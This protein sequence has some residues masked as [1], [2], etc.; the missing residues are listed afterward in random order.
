MYLSHFSLTNFRNFARLD[1]DVPRGPVIVYGDNAQGKTSLL[2]AI[3]YLATFMSFHATNDQQLIHLWAEKEPVV[4]SR[5]AT[6]FYRSADQA[7]NAPH[8]ANR[9]E[10]RL[11]VDENG[12]NGARRLRKE[13]LL[14]G[15][16]KKV[17]EVIGS[18]TA[19]LFLPQ[20]LQIIEGSPDDRR[21]Y[22]N[23]AMAQVLPHFAA[24][25][26]DYNQ[27]V[28]QRNALLKQ[29]AEKGIDSRNAAGQLAYWDEQLARK[30]S[31]IISHRIRA[32]KDLDRIA[33]RVHRDLTQGQEALRLSYIP[34]FELLQAPVGQFAL[35]INTVID[36]S[37]LSQEKI[38]ER[39][40]DLIQ[41]SRPEELARGITKYGPHRDEL[42]FLSNQLDLGIY[43]SRGQ[44]RSA[45]MSM[46]L[47]EVAWMKER[48]GEWPV[49][50]LDEVLAELDP[51]RRV[52]LLH[53]LLESE[54]AVMTTTDLDMFDEKFVRTAQV[55]HVTAGQISREV[56]QQ[57]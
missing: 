25:L 40:I 16:K 24:T 22:L 10:V 51:I 21:R 7:S 26:T 2:E 45:V 53:Y 27:V 49:L 18:F 52:D 6:T 36:R 38:Y 28:S 41:Q 31:E 17:S 12:G 13:I 39:F 56:R 14:D 1:I 32:I 35:P 57:D 46:K 34:S 42:R 50:L 44:V 8:K 4:V 3:Y 20:M 11:I 23:L 9:I 5:I 54:Q 33:A 29:L 37:S 55:W 48:S 19:V 15:V 47:A 30:G 43:G